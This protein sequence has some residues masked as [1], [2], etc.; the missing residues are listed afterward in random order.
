MDGDAENTNTQAPTPP[1]SY[2]TDAMID[3]N[4][5]PPS[6][7]TP[8]F[9]YIIVLLFLIVVA[10]IVV[11]FCALRDP[12]FQAEET[13]MI[14]SG[15]VHALA[16][17]EA[18]NEALQQVN[19]NPAHA[20]SL[21]NH[22]ST[23]AAAKSDQ[24]MDRE[25]SY[26]VVNPPN[27][28]TTIIRPS[29]EPSSDMNPP[30]PTPVKPPLMESSDFV[31]TSK[32][33]ESSNFHE[34]VRYPPFVRSIVYEAEQTCFVIDAMYILTNARFEVYVPGVPK[35]ICN[36]ER[37][38]FQSATV[39]K[40]P[41]PCPASFLAGTTCHV[42]IVNPDSQSF[43][44][45]EPIATAPLETLR[46]EKRKEATTTTNFIAKQY[47]NSFGPLVPSRTLKVQV[48]MYHEGA[49]VLDSID[50]PIEIHLVDV[51]NGRLVQRQVSFMQH[52]V[53]SC[54][55]HD[56][57]PNKTYVVRASPPESALRPTV[58]EAYS[59]ESRNLF[60]A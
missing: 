40:V 43:F 22:V 20:A 33:I 15:N 38:M 57:I 29:Q 30:I 6:Q 41:N 31:A 25:P 9:I 23:L 10:L 36:I 45:Y 17:A 19:G 13:Q 39:L 11:M 12:C 8:W 46:D 54:T 18:F 5:V 24:A 58:P 14:A 52:G 51:G 59:I 53:C 56:I 1:K 32:T 2:V 28:T 42:R 26:K 44:L 49:T 34:E 16:V 35:F 4:V 55:F 50:Q 37:D 48:L 27:A 7:A 47:Y 21:A 60:V 3:K